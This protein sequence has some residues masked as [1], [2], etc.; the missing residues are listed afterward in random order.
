M[1]HIGHDLRCQ[2][3]LTKGGGEVTDAERIAELEREVQRGLAQLRD[4]RYMWLL[5]DLRARDKRKK[6]RRAT[7]QREKG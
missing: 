3:W 7:K 1:M 5:D 4:M 2:A 6:P